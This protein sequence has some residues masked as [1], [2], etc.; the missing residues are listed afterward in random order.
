MVARAVETSADLAVYSP[1][2][3]VGGYP[4]FLGR[5]SASVADSGPLCTAR[6][7]WSGRTPAGLRN[8]RCER[9][10]NRASRHRHAPRG[11][12]RG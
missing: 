12:L 7:R 5:G 8:R 6:P 11:H 9:G 2:H 3:A 4:G 1:H 10:C